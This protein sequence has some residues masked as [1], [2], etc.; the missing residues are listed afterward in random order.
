MVIL[1]FFLRKYVNCNTILTCAMSLCTSLHC[2]CKK[3]EPDVVIGCFELC[4][5]PLSGTYL[6][7]RST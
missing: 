6:G 4:V 2:G 5:F 3:K 7:T 1:R